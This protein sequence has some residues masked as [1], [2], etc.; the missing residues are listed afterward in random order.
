MSIQAAA[1]DVQVTQDDLVVVGALQQVVQVVLHGVNREAVADG[2]NLQAAADVSHVLV[3]VV[4]DGAVDG[5]LL[6]V[7]L[8]GVVGTGIDGGAHAAVGD[9]D[10]THRIAGGV[11]FQ[12]QQILGLD[13]NDL[14][15][16]DVGQGEVAGADGGIVGDHS[17]KL[18]QVTDLVA[19]LVQVQSTGTGHVLVAVYDLDAVGQQIELEGQTAVAVIHVADGGATVGGQGVTVDLVAGQVLHLDFVHPHLVV[20]ALTGG[21]GSQ[22]GAGEGNL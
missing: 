14:G 15:A 13:V 22:T 8:V 11:I 16:V 12:I 18:H 3:A 2:Q 19:V 6:A 1:A 17:T 5:H 21:G 4:L 10:D 20:G 7:Q 9:V